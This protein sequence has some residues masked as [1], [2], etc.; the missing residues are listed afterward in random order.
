[1]SEGEVQPFVEAE[2]ERNRLVDRAESGGDGEIAGAGGDDKPQ[3]RPDGKDAEAPDARPAAQGQS[4]SGWLGLPPSSGGSFN[5]TTDTDFSSRL[6]RE[7][8]LYEHLTQQLH[9]N[10]DDAGDRLIGGLLIGM[11]DDAGYLTGE[12]ATVAETIGADIGDVER[13]LRILQ[14][15]DPPGVCARNLQECLELQLKERGRFDPAMAKFIARLDLVAKREFAS[16]QKLCGVS[17]DDVADM[18]KE[19]KALNPKPGNAFGSLFLQAVIPDVV[20]KPASDGGWLVELNS[21]TLPRLLVNRQYLA[22]VS[23]SGQREEDKVY[24]SECLANAQWLVKSL[25]QRARTILKVAKEIVRQQD[26]FLVE[27]VSKLKPLNLKTVAEAIAMHESTVS[28]VTSNK[29]MA[30][31]RGTFELKYFFTT[32]LSSTSGAEDLHSAEAV[33][34]RIRQM[35]DAEAPQ[36]VLSDDQIVSQLKAEGIDLARRTVAKYREALGIASSVQRRRDKHLRGSG[37]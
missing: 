3:A 32:G 6:A 31:P 14:D 13:V 29:F 17:L 11:I 1:M 21:E 5:A 24:L 35:I 30:T 7:T 33:R 8:T 2:L 9:V 18:V 23:R 36:A 15:F 4:D 26:S 12:L 16:L 19:V 27:G 28:R 25:D 37:S 20:V 34:H 22:R 10:V